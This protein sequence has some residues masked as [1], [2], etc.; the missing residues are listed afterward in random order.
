MPTKRNKIKAGPKLTISSALIGRPNAAN[1][2]T[3]RPP[4][5]AERMAIILGV[6]FLSIMLVMSVF[7]VVSAYENPASWATFVFFLGV[8]GFIL[9][10][11]HNVFPDLHGQKMFYG[12]GAWFLTFLTV[13]YIIL[14]LHQFNF[15]IMV[16][17]SVLLVIQFPFYMRLFTSDERWEV[18]KVH[19]TSSFKRGMDATVA[20]GKKTIKKPNKN[21]KIYR[22]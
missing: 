17:V 7:S 20:K 21:R 5:S 11:E 13:P 9:F 2:I 10:H 18:F 6:G 19:V 1:L 12:I 3:D 22:K 16:F 14:L 8:L 4:G 15:G